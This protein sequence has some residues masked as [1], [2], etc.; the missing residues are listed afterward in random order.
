MIIEET[1]KVNTHILYLASKNTYNIEFPAGE[2]VLKQSIK[3]KILF[4]EAVHSDLIF[5]ARSD[6]CLQ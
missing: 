2:K 6:E 5:S 4:I 1:G 3:I